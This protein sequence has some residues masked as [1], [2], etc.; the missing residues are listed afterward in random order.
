MNRIT[1]AIT[2]MRE[3]VLMEDVKSSDLDMDF[4]E[5]CRF[6]ELK[7]LAAVEGVL[8]QEEAMT[9]YSLLGETVDT[10]NDQDWATKAV[11]TKIFLELLCKQRG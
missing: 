4:E 10:F 1:N 11:L 3:S 6:Q 8:S 5:Y 9:V 2:K 7:S